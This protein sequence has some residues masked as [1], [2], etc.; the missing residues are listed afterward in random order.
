LASVLIALIS[1]TRLGP[2]LAPFD[3]TRYHP[4]DLVVFVGAVLGLGLGLLALYFLAHSAFILVYRISTRLLHIQWSGRYY[5]EMDIHMEAPLDDTTVRHLLDDLYVPP[6]YS[7]D[8]ITKSVKAHP[9]VKAA[10]PGLEFWNSLFWPAF[11]RPARNSYRAER[12]DANE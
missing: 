12:E 8:F 7:D 6:P 4:S 10:K 9:D 5:Y 1:I 3:P 11:R 2:T